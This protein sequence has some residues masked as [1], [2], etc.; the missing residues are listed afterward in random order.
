MSEFDLVIGNGTV[1]TAANTASCDIGSKDGVITTLGRRLGLRA[2]QYVP[3]AL[4]F[5]DKSS[6]PFY[7]INRKIPVREAFAY[8]WVIKCTAIK[9]LHACR[10]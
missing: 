4:L 6:N 5:F 1:A 3:T 2:R 10:I 9:P 7:K 8:Y